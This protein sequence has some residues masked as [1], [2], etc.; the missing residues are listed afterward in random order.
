MLAIGF[1]C[2][3]Q[4]FSKILFLGAQKALEGCIIENLEKEATNRAIEWK[5]LSIIG[6]VG[7]SL[8]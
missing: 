4:F 5:I 6:I 1:P 8:V 3:L 7:I 2:T